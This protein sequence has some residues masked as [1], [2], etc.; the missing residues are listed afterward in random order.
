MHHPW[1]IF[2]YLQ[3]S[4]R[5]R[6]RHQP[7]SGVDRVRFCLE[8]GADPNPNLLW[9]T[10]S[11]FAIATQYAS[12]KVAA[13]M[14]KY[15]V[16][17]KGSG[18]LALASR[19]GKMHTVKF[20]LMKGALIDEYCVTCEIDTDEQDHEGTALHLVKRRRVDTFEVFARERD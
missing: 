10:N 19:Y 12:V 1:Q 7:P 14:L 5:R 11:P 16:R 20:L 18:A 9:D 13:L 17:L 6:F 4:R 15:N 3:A 8:N 2:Q